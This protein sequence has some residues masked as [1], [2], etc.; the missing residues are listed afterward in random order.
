MRGDPLKFRVRSL[1][2]TMDLLWLNEFIV[3][4]SAGQILHW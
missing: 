1:K 2:C 3:L 4:D